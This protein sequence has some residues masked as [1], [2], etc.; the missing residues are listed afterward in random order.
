MRYTNLSRIKK[1]SGIRSYRRN[2]WP[3][4]V[5][6][7][8]LDFWQRWF[9]FPSYGNR[10]IPRW[11]RH[12][13]CTCVRAPGW[14]GGARRCARKLNIWGGLRVRIHTFAR[15]PERYI[16]PPICSSWGNPLLGEARTFAT[17]CERSVHARIATFWNFWNT[18]RAREPFGPCVDAK[19]MYIHGPLR[20]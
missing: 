18:L 7:C 20:R 11:L 14:S 15:V 2:N 16:V 9:F 4:A 17:N 5:I 6:K 12:I 3:T 10:C 19:I 8:N 1:F 13:P